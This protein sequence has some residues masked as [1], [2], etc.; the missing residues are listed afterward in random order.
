MRLRLET[1]RLDELRRQQPGLQLRPVSDGELKLAGELEFSAEAPG[2][3]RLNDRYDVEIIVPASFPREPPLVREVG[4]RIPATF[5][6]N[7]DGTLCLGSPAKLRLSLLRTPTL[8]GFVNQ[9]V[10]PYLYGYT[11][12]EKHGKLPFGEL[13]HG[14]AGL[15]QEFAGFFGLADG[16]TAA[17]LVR[18]AGMRK[19]VANKLPCPCGSGRRLGRCHHLAVNRLRYELGRKWLRQHSEQI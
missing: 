15:R 3:D 5:H 2:Y 16:R 19:R 11:H 10:V 6:T 4:G 1:L 9:C 17:A 12:W 18:L 7:P 13:A 8:P 14:P